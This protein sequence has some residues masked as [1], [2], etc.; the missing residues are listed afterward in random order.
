MEFRGG[1]NKTPRY[2]ARGDGR[3]QT[4]SIERRI[5]SALKRAG[6]RQEPLEGELRRDQKKID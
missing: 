2:T 1:S 3:R 6:P 5:G 4:R